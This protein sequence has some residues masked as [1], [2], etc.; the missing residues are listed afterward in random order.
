MLPN[1]IAQSEGNGSTQD[2]ASVFRTGPQK[3]QWS[4]HFAEPFFGG[5]LSILGNIL[6]RPNVCW[7]PQHS[8]HMLPK[9]ILFCNKV[10]LTALTN[11]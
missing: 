6:G 8:I 9:Q 10:R 4:S 11:L 3:T 1:F 7:N 5:I 2:R